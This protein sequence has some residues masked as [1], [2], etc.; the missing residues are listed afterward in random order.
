VEPLAF[1]EVLGRHNDV[2]ARH[3]VYRWPVRAGRGYDVDVILD[4]PFVA[5]R[6][7]QIEP[8]VDGRF[9]VTDLQSVN[10]ITLPPSAQRVEAAEVGPDDIVRLGQTQIRVRATGYEVRPELALRALAWYRRALSFAIMSAALLGLV[11]WNAWITTTQQEERALLVFPALGVGIAVAVWISIWSL[12]SRTVGGRSNFAAHGF[13]AC[14]GLTAL[15]L[16]DALA[17][18]LAFGFHAR[19]LD[20]AGALASAAVFAYMFYRHL[21]LNS[22][23]SRRSLGIVSV[24][25]SV[26]AFGGA[27]GLE[28]AGESGKEGVQRYDQTLKPPAFLM[29]HGVTPE[30][31]IG[32]GEQL[33]SK[34]DAMARAQP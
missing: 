24:I 23:A 8:A 11:V 15:A 7:L 10:G 32:E 12:V 33:K 17:E 31:F 25:V 1:I 26:A 29:V 4:D 14:A 3:P 9:R 28:M 30:A 21:R 20:Y 16:A 5:P 6:H 27:A 19:W 13:I 18:Y 22:R 34:V 2:L